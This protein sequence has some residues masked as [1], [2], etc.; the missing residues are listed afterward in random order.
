MALTSQFQ[1]TKPPRNTTVYYIL[2]AFFLK[3]TITYAEN[4]IILQYGCTITS[5]SRWPSVVDMMAIGNT[6]GHTHY[7]YYF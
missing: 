3:L 2:V 1:V 5:P 7:S 4:N 6:N